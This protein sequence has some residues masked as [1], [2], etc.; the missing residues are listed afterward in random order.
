MKRKQTQATIVTALL[1]LLGTLTLILAPRAA[2]AGNPSRFSGPLSSQPLA[3]SADGELL[4][5]E[6]GDAAAP[7]RAYLD[8]AALERLLAARAAGMA[9]G[10][11]LS[12][13]R[14]GVANAW[15]RSL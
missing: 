9:P 14:A 15:L 1:C 10:T 7:L 5:G 3:L 12:L 6:L 11:A 8:G 4:A 2:K 13:W